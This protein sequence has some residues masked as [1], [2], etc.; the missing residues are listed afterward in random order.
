MKKSFSK[1]GLIAVMS[2][3][4]LAL[5]N[6]ALAFSGGHADGHGGGHGKMAKALDLSET[7]AAQFKQ[8]H[9][10]AKPKMQQLRERIHENRE[11]MYKL[12]PASDGYML[13][14]NRLALDRASLVEQKM[15]AHARLRADVAAILTPKQRAKA[16]EMHE[17]RRAK[18]KAWRDEHAKDGGDMRPG[19]DRRHGGDK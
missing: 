5:A 4:V 16:K 6:P 3:A 10:K 18:H 15:K 9:R 11:A 14:V 2:I 8:L 7:Q 19:M 17:K 1:A 13:Q 12:D